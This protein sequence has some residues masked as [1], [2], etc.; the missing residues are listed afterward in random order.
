MSF[1]FFE[2]YIYN[3]EHS[4]IHNQNNL[5]FLIV[6]YIF[7]ALFKIYLKIFFNNCIIT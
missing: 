1:S 3:A 6:I 7:L 5:Q 4:I 2:E